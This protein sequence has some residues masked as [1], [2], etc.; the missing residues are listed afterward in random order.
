MKK[1]VA[2]VIVFAIAAFALM[3]TAGALAEEEDKE[4]D[5]APAATVTPEVEMVVIDGDPATDAEIGSVERPVPTINQ[6]QWTEET[7]RT[8]AK[9]LYSFDTGKEKFLASGVVVNRWLCGKT[10]ADGTPYFGSGT[11]ESVIKQPG[12][13]ECYDEKSRVTDYNM[14]YAEFCLNVHTTRNLTKLYTGYAF[15]N[16]VLYLGWEPDG[17]LAAYVNLGGEP[18]FFGQ[19]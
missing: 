12:E 9:F 3:C 19:E 4:Q 1:A 13:F 15:P 6:Y 11:I 2:L 8:M 18:F 7:L 17:R 14:E 10:K 5:P 16:T